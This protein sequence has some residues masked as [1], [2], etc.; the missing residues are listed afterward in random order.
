MRR[1]AEERWGVWPLPFGG[2]SRVFA[3]I[4]S[5]KRPCRKIERVS[6]HMG[7]WFGPSNSRLTVTVSF[8]H[9]VIITGQ[10]Q[11]QSGSESSGHARGVD[12]AA[13]LKR[14]SRREGR[15]RWS[16]LLQ[17]WQ[18]RR[19]HHHHSAAATHHPAD[20]QVGQE[21]GESCGGTSS[22]Y[23]RRC[24]CGQAFFF[25]KAWSVSP[26]PTHSWLHTDKGEATLPPVS[27]SSCRPWS[28][29]CF[30]GPPPPQ[31]APGWGRSC[32]HRSPSNTGGGEPRKR[33]GEE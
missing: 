23:D 7:T 17:R 14:G 11:Q 22:N 33:E 20:P 16:G 26:A 15:W 1:S 28:P 30:S 13:G 9:P 3:L 12:G 25:G 10:E 8:D 5:I 6:M 27:V 24:V 19:G 32:S 4:E 29:W 31:P 18:Q 21:C 2:I